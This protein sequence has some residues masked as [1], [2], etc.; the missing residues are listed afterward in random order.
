[1][2]VWLMTMSDLALSSP[3]SLTDPLTIVEF[4]IR[5]FNSKIL[6]QALFVDAAKVVL[7]LDH[8]TQLP[9]VAALM[10]SS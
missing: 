7:K 3:R 10:A 6:S 2:T 9:I 5:L 4:Q 8:L 1:M